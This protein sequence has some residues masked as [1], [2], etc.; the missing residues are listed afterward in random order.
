MDNDTTDIT[1]ESTIDWAN[2]KTVVKPVN[3]NGIPLFYLFIGA[4]IMLILIILVI[5]LVESRNKDPNEMD[6]LLDGEYQDIVD[7]QDHDEQGDDGQN[8]L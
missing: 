5:S 2:T 8:D 6:I 7:P 4:F 1:F 3:E